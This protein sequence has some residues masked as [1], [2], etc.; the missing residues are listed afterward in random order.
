MH[1]VGRLVLIPLLCR[2]NIYDGLGGIL[3]YQVNSFY[4]SDM[5]VAFILEC[6]ST[7]WSWRKKHTCVSNFI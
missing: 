1:Y 6:S 4:Q 7:L 2:H 3:Y 5:T